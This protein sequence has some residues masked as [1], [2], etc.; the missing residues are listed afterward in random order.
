MSSRNGFFTGVVATVL[1][2]D[3]F[4]PSDRCA[5][6]QRSADVEGLRG[7]GSADEGE[8]GES[9]GE[10]GVVDGVGIGSADSLRAGSALADS[11]CVG[12]A[13]CMAGWR[14]GAALGGA[15][16]GG[17]AAPAEAL[18]DDD[19][20]RRDRGPDGRDSTAW[21]TSET[22]PATDDAG[23]VGKAGAPFSGGV[24]ASARDWSET[25]CRK[26]PPVV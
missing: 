16:L 7:G 2:D 11:L 13:S 18:G 20:L 6:S 14:G 24:A 26:A 23:V 15:A 5:S 8:A 10:M 22:R 25:L 12:T 21:S 17:G 19:G 3:G 9:F 1:G 4:P